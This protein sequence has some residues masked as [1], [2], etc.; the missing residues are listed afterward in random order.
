MQVGNI[1]K[2]K[3]QSIAA[4]DWGRGYINMTERKSMVYVGEG[5]EVIKPEI[6]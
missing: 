2:H 1:R 5:K 6:Q 4:A 3:G